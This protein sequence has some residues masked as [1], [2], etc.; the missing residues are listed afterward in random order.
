MMIYIGIAGASSK[1]L[2]YNPAPHG[3]ARLPSDALLLEKKYED[4]L[5]K[6]VM[7][8][9]A[10]EDDSSGYAL[11]I[12]PTLRAIQLSLREFTLQHSKLVREVLQSSEAVE[13]RRAAALFLGSDDASSSQVQALAQASRDADAIVRNN[14]VRALGVLASSAKTGVEVPAEPFIDLLSSNKWTDRNKGAFALMSL[15]QS[16]APRVLAEL[17]KKAMPALVEMARWQFSGHASAARTVLG[18]IGG[19]NEAALLRDL[20]SS[21]VEVLI[22]AAIKAH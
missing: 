12:A 2:I 6:A 22:D 1:P 19:M 21:E 14:A 20:N 4:A 15:T 9:S 13:H 7:E 10:Q 5:G 18:R 17:R 8:G 3:P 11:S 16:R